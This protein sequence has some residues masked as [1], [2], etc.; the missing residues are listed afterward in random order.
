[1]SFWDLSDGETAA[2]TPKEYEVPGGNMEPIPNNSDVLAIIDE[3][4]WTTNGNESDPREYIS[5]RWSVMAPEQFKNRK[6]FHKIWVTDFDPNAKDEAAA[7]LKRDKNRKML[8]A[9]DAN[10]GGMLTKSGDTPT[11]DALAMHLTNKPMVI[12]CMVWSMKGNDGND[13]KGNWISAVSPSDKALHVGEAT[14]KPA[15]SGGSSGGGRAD[16]DDEIPF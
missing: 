5:A 11:S 10:S 7:K 3:I 2:D 13:M 1:M 8:A 12:K 15:A 14:K 6:V 16:L 4:K 9:I